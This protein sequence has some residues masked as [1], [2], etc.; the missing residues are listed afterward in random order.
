MKWQIDP[1]HTSV[2]AAAKHMGFTTVRVRF[3]GASGEIEFDPERPGTAKV[4][5]LSIPVAQLNSGDDRRDAH[6]RS[7]DFFDADRAPTITFRSTGVRTVGEGRYDVAG[8]LTIRGTT[9]PVALSVAV[10]G[11]V[12]DPM[13]PGRQ[14]AFVDAKTRIDRRDWGLVWNMPIPQGVLVSND[15]ALEIS[16]QLVSEVA[17]ET[18][19]AA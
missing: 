13:R 12:A 5:D 10:H 16:S 18:A 11:I 2:E 9:K 15:I 6:L 3:P 8:D 1:A 14:R 7:A 17:E 4:V 19:K